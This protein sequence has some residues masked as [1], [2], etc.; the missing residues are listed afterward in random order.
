MPDFVPGSDG[1]NTDEGGFLQS[2][3]EPLP[4]LTE[5]PPN[6]P[7]VTESSTP[8]GGARIRVDATVRQFRRYP[9][10]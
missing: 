4:S 8:S 7:M 6:T 9:L 2:L 5:T 3:R 1:T 10:W